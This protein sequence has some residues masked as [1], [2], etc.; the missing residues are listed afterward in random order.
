MKATMLL[1]QKV[2]LNHRSGDRQT[3]FEFV[4]WEIPRSEHYPEGTKYRA[5]LS[6][7]GNTVFGFDYPNPK[8][9]IFILVSMRWDMY[10]ED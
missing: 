9:L 10:I 7:N 6:E 2:V 8:V 1:H 3:K 5:W 4:V